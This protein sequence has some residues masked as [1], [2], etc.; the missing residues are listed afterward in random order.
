[1]RSMEVYDLRTGEWA[2]GPEM[3]TARHHLGVTA[4]D[5]KLYALG[6]RVPGEFSVDAAERFDPETGRWEVTAPAA[7]GHGRTSG[8]LVRP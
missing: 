8:G 4:L 3:P 5:G 2:T 6:G 7:P 1:M